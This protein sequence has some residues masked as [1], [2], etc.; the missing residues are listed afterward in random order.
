MLSYTRRFVPDLEDIV[1]FGDLVEKAHMATEAVTAAKY[2]H[3]HV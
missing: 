1:E 2:I 3:I